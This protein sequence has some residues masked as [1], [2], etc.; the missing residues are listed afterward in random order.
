LN[1]ILEGIV[2]KQTLILS[3]GCADV[4][5][6]SVQGVT[7]Y[8]S[9]ATILIIESLVNILATNILYLN[10]KRFDNFIQASLNVI[11][12]LILMEAI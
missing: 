6:S 1:I 2:S 7:P 9:P 4:R 12:N 5:V 11:E 10:I 3:T 8:A